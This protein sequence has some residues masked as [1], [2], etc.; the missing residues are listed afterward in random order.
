MLIDEKTVVI[1][2]D[3]INHIADTDLDINVIVK[4]MKI[5]FGHLG[6]MAIIHP[7]VYNFETPKCNNKL[8][9]CFEE[10]VVEVV[11]FDDIFSDEDEKKAYYIYLI[12]ELYYALNGSQLD[13]SND[14]ILKKWKSGMS[15]G[16]IH[17][18]TTCMVCNC[19]VFLSDD[20]DS[21][22]LQDYV[23]QKFLADIIVYNRKEVFDKYIETGGNEIGRKER[24]PLSHVRC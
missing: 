7:L 8:N 3:F 5:L 16:E 14:E 23:K 9:Q 19:K 2:N 1:D 18:V 10:N 11:T 13:F 6:V 12:K 22:I 17:S 15:L 21:K 4:D 20:K 24:R